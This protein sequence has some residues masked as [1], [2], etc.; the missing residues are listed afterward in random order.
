MGPGGPSPRRRLAARLVRLLRSTTAS[1]V[2]ETAV[3]LP[4]FF[5][6]VFGIFEFSLVL[7]TYCN[8]TVATSQ[9]TRYASMHSSSSLSPDT[10]SQ[11]K[12]MVTSRLFVGSI[13]PTV[14]VS[15]LTQTLTTGTNT[16]GNLVM[17]KCSWAQTV[18]VPF[19]P[20]NSFSIASQDVR[21]ITR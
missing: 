21:Q 11:L 5:V 17:I 3:A 1:V 8:A 9:A 20:S 2:I 6:V 7:L 18:T 16:V 10:T 4:I 13:T 14:T 15:Y 12:S 19:S